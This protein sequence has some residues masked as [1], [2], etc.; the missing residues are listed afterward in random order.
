MTLCQIRGGD[1][2]SSKSEGAD[3][4]SDCK[5]RVH[6]KFSDNMFGDKIKDARDGKFEDLSKKARL[7]S[8]VDGS[9]G[10]GKSKDNGGTP[11]TGSKPKSGN[12]EENG[13]DNKQE[14]EEENDEGGEEAGL[15]EGQE[16]FGNVNV[17]PTVEP[18]VPNLASYSL[19]E[20]TEETNERDSAPWTSERETLCGPR[21]WREG[22]YVVSCVPDGSVIVTSEM[23]EKIKLS[24]GALFAEVQEEHRPLLSDIFFQWPSTFVRLGNVSA[25]CR[26]FALDSLVS[27]VEV[28]ENVSLPKATPQDFESVYDCLETLVRYRLEVD[29]LRKRIDQMASLLEL[30]VVRHQLE[31]VSKELEEIEVVA[32]RLKD[33]K[34][35]LEGRVAELESVGSGRFDVSSHAGQGLRR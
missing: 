20:E 5:S 1:A 4:R 7:K 26:K 27:F 13:R 31:K 22:D 10:D 11:K 2:S 24:P 18:L 6:A 9:T 34:K 17:G 23:K 33:K 14:D 28:L 32:M 16:G 15:V 19:W 12:P 25:I 29:W 35:G 8:N 21:R 3:A 30:S